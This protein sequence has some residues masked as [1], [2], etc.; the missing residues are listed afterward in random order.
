VIGRL[1]RRARRGQEPVGIDLGRDAIRLAQVHWNGDEAE[2]SLVESHPLGCD[3]HTTLDEYHAAVDRT[4]RELVSQKRLPSTKVV[5]NLWSRTSKVR[6]VHIPPVPEAELGDALRSEIAR[7]DDLDPLQV[8]IDFEPVG[9]VTARGTEKLA[10][11]V[12]SATK[13]EVDAQV[14]RL[15][16]LGL[17]AV[18]IDDITLAV[19]RLGRH[20]KP[21]E[22]DETSALLLA[23]QTSTS[24]VFLIGG[25][26]Q[27]Y[28][29][30]PFG[31]REIV[32]ELA[33][34][35]RLDESEVWQ[36]KDE[37]TSGRFDDYREAGDEAL[38][39]FVDRLTAE[40]QRSIAYFSFQIARTS[41]RDLSRI[42]VT[43]SFPPAGALQ[44]RLAQR[45]PEVPVLEFPALQ[46]IGVNP[47]VPLDRIGRNPTEMAG[48][49][50]LALWREVP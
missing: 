16:G 22:Q 14:Q 9:T 19:A 34:S 50:G 37:I 40:L 28:R 3:A 25:V 1:F 41:K 33:K 45:F 17:E 31:G 6:V 42:E 48:A 46:N 24:I 49:V 8:A 36:R 21:P 32:T 15:R 39:G 43:G 38:G 44:P 30:V 2:L 11:L 4:L 47:D 5:T 13:T 27:Y 20:G 29:E 23:G 12:L 35:L 26:V 7:S 10:A 18:A